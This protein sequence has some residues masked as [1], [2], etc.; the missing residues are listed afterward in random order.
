M[1]IKDLQECK[2]ITAGDNSKLRELLQ[3]ARDGLKIRYSLAYARVAPGEMT[4]AHRLKSSSEVYYIL[5]GQGR[6][7]IA[8]EEADVAAGQ[9]VYIPP[10]AVQRIKNTGT[11]DLIFLCIVDPAWRPEDEEIITQ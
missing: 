2:E 10:G 8:D 11:E 6:M 5:A 7:Y 3:P 9:V 4:L 1:F